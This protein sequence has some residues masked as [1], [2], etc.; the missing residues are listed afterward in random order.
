VRLL[1]DVS[2]PNHDLWAMDKQSLGADRRSFRETKK[3]ID[4]STASNFCELK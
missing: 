4:R 1:Q 2:T 3:V